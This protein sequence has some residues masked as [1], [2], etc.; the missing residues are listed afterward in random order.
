MRSAAVLL[1]AI[2]ALSGGVARAWGPEGH[3]L[4]A[5]LAEG[6]L[7]AKTKEALVPLLEG[8]TLADI[9]S[10]ADDW[11]SFHGNTGRWHYVDVPLEAE[12]YD[13]GRDC[14]R[15]D[16]VV[17]ALEAEIAKL[18]NPRTGALERRRALRFVVHLV[19]DLHQPLHAVD[20][21]DRGGNQIRA[22]LVLPG[23]EFPYRS[24]RDANLHSVWDNDLLDSAHRD[25]DTYLAAL[26]PAPGAVAKLQEGE[27]RDWVNEAHRLAQDPAYARLPP[28]PSEPFQTLQLDVAYVQACRPVAESQLQKA[29]MRLA[30]IL[31]AALGTR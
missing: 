16:C 7:S 21:D 13:E 26:T 30:R 31:N 2:L 10:W 15:G 27:L 19:G 4:V 29:G 8:R 12:R 9:A 24:M 14:P 17:R 3:V 5:R 20:H 18:G 28:L 22:Q 6:Q 1:G 25:Q 23:G 11:R